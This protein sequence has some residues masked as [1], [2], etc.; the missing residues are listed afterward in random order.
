MEVIYKE[1]LMQFVGGSGYSSSG[2]YG[3][4]P[5]GYC[6]FNAMAYIFD[7]NTANAWMYASNYEANYNEVR[8]YDSNGN[9]TG[10]SM[11]GN[12][13]RNVISSADGGYASVNYVS[14]GSYSNSMFNGGTRILAILPNMGPAGEQHAV[15]IT[16]FNSDGTFNY[17]D[18]TTG[19]DVYSSGATVGN[20]FSI[21]CQ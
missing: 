6:L 13:M 9:F 5:N 20:M 10:Y 19:N 1:D 14:S 21:Q 3:P 2:G 17:Y 16:S 12:E 8:N 7:G 11:S 4:L 18:A 15:E